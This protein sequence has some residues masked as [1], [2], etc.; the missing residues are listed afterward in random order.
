MDD[1]HSLTNITEP[2]SLHEDLLGL[3]FDPSNVVRIRAEPSS[4]PRLYPRNAVDGDSTDL[5]AALVTAVCS[6]NHKLV[7]QLLHRGVPANTGPNMHALREAIH[8]HDEESIRLLLLFGADPNY[9]SKDGVTPLLA[10]VDKS[11]LGGA[12]MLLKY[13]ADPNLVGGP[14]H[15]S[16]LAV[17]VMANMVGLSHLLMTYNGD[18]N[19]V[20]ASGTPLLTSAI[21]KKT[22]KKFID[23]LLE[24]GSN[25]NTKSKEGKTALFE[26]IQVGRADIVT[27]LLE[28]GADPNLPGPKHMLWPATHQS[29]CLQALL[30][31][32]ADHKKCP[33]IIELAVS[34][35]SIESVRILLKAGVSPNVKKDGT[36]TPLCTAIRDDRGD[37]L[38][39]LLSNGADPN[40][41]ASE[42]PAFKCVTHNRVHFLPLLVSSGANIHSPKGILETAVSFNNVEALNWLLDQGVNPNDKNPKGM[43]PLTTAIREN[44]ADLVDLLLLRGADPHMRGQDWPICMAVRNPPI[45][46]RILT[47]VSEP[48]AFKG[49]MEMAVSANQLESV[50]LL[51]AAGV[52][53]EDK[54]GGVFSPLTT[55]IREDRR[56]IVSY[57]LDVAGVDVN[58]PGEHLPIVKALRR[59]HGENDT[60]IMELLLNHGADP[61]K[62][63]RGWNGIMQALE[64]GDADI[65][66]FLSRK[67]G[68]DLKVKDEMGRTV[69]E[70]AASRGWDEAVQILLDGDVT[71]R[72]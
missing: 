41:M 18:V 27:S 52:S 9:P 57:L 53:V 62:M 66:K 51:K 63:Y 31:H 70:M 55:A 35:N 29:Q 38:E 40:L 44:R 21:K 43:S 17:A 71:L 42:Y 45:L 65:L 10:C 69:V 6:K 11:F 23:L 12:T 32:G 25:P 59:Y 33:G 24:Y 2:D 50:K 34:F 22:P 28:H 67:A 1:T 61:N 4:M 30:S 16:P 14:D 64:N 60:E 8:A 13:G 39:L 20:T 5:K 72:K 58:A 3:D 36:Y 54:N 15:E 68:V 37:L 49:I 46:K 47:V 56:E 19:H 7:E 48:K 26:A